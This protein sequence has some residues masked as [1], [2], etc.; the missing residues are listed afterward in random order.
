MQEARK[1]CTQY[2]WRAKVQSWRRWRVLQPIKRLIMAVRAP[3]TCDYPACPDTAL[4]H[5]RYCKR[6]QT[7]TQTQ[8]PIKEQKP[9]WSKWYHR[10]PWPGPHGLRALVLREEPICR[11]CQRRA[12]TIADHIVPHKGIWQLFV[13]RKNLQGLCAECHN[14]K[15][16][17]EDGG[18]G[19]APR[20]ASAP[21]TTGTTGKQFSSSSVGEDAIDAALKEP[22]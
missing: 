18:F 10:K 7:P 17:T 13:D 15:T 2:H 8:E 5:S 19:S 20:D 16:A 22:I 9:F 14:T 21:V 11:M 12:S 6:H 3:I 4:E 1:A